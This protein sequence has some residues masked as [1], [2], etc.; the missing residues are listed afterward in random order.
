MAISYVGGASAAATSLTL[1]THQ[2]DD[3]LLLFAYRSGSTS[4]PTVPAGWTAIDQGG[5][6]N[7]SAVIAYRIATASGTTSGTWTNATHIS[8]TA[9]RSGSGTLAI[10]THTSNGGSGDIL[11]YGG[12]TLQ[13]ADNSSWVA[14]FGGHRQATNVETAPSGMTNRTSTA[15]SGESAAHDT[16]GTVSTWT[17]QTVTVSPS[18]GGTQGWRTAVVEIREVLTRILAADVRALVLTGVA[19]GLF[20]AYKLPASVN[21]FTL[22]GQAAEKVRTYIE[23]AVSNVY[24]LTGQD[25]T[26]ARSWLFSV[27]T[28]NYILTGQDSTS[29]LGK[30]VA[31]DPGSFALTG[32]DIA[33]FRNYVL[34]PLT[35]EYTT[36]GDAEFI[37]TYIWSVQ[38][39]SYVLTGQNS[40]YFKG[41][42]VINWEANK[43]YSLNTIVAPT[44]PVVNGIVFKAI[45]AGTS[46]TTE[47]FWPTAFGGT[48][49]DGGITWQAVSRLAGVLQEIAPSAIIEL[50]QLQLTQDLHGVNE[51]YY[52]HAGLNQGAIANITWRGQSYIAFPVQAEGFE[53]NGQGQLPRPKIQISN[54]LSTISALILTLPSGLEGAKITRIRTLARY[55]DPSNFL[56][57]IPAGYAP[58]QTAEFPREIYYIDRKS[59][60]TRDIVEFELAAVFDLAG[61]RAPKRACIANV[62]QWVYRSTECGYTG[63][64]Y[65]NENDQVVSSLAQD[66]CGK[67]LSSCKAR[68][69]KII[70]TGNVTN[71]STTLTVNTTNGLVA[72][73]P[74]YGF[75]IPTGTTISSITNSTQLVMSQAATASNPASTSGTPSSTI[76]QMTVASASALQAKM[77]VTGT[78]IPNGTTIASISGTTLTLSARPY[79]FTRQGTFIYSSNIYGVTRYISIVTSSMAVGMRVFGSNGI[80]T[81]IAT[82]DAVNN[83][84]TLNSYGSLTSASNNIT[85][86]LYFM[87][88]S[89]SSSTYTFTASSQIIFRTQSGELPFGSYPGIGAFSI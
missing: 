9:Y 43:A 25:A 65:F 70:R 28:G 26:L 33:W 17:A 4:P 60:E 10:G 69:D 3:L 24:T 86:I 13:D 67:R 76:A 47:P 57:E 21:A 51:T 83:R 58:D 77:T 88:A 63:S 18:S 36:T 12:I 85:V 11:T 87:P 71:D 53:Y 54:V 78:Y 50:F 41:Q 7:N 14:G 34:N 39:Q 61:I 40:N 38:S 49:V 5:N 64:N 27:N 22:T 80:D 75:A 56:G 44:T 89:P 6:N 1:P 52:F 23:P 79:S 66:E 72:G 82:V 2:A 84:I 20:A 68:F 74:V 81:T 42:T 35:S 73:L 16:N 30:G 55:L 45:T 37:R 19:A 15:T 62:C 29:L 8:S 46:S 59:A 48:V 32:Q 31:T